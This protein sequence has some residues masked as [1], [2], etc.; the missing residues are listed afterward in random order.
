[1]KKSQAADLKRLEQYLLLTHD[2][3][4][5]KLDNQGYSVVVV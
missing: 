5:T 4:Q 2:E 1:M 3:L